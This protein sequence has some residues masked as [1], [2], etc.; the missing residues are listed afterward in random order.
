VILIASDA[1]Q[2][3]CQQDLRANERA[4]LSTPVLAIGRRPIPRLAQSDHCSPKAKVTRS[5]R[6]G[7]A[8]SVQD[9]ALQNLPFLRLD[10]VAHLAEL[11]CVITRKQRLLIATDVIDHQQCCAPLHTSSVTRSCGYHEKLPR[12]DLAHATFGVHQDSP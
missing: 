9:W 5:N 6:V 10:D 8:I 3:T 1:F 4:R 12:P 11:W 2:Q 7:R